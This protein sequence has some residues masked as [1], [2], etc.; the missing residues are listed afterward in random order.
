MTI[1]LRS[2]TRSSRTHDPTTDVE[3]SN[4]PRHLGQVHVAAPMWSRQLTLAGES[5]YVGTRFSSFGNHVPGGWLTNL[6]LTWVRPHH[7]LSLSARV[8]NVFD[9]EY[10]HPVGFEFRQDVIPQDGR[11]ISVRATLRF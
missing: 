6:N 7:P 11:T 9:R 5:Q 4:S 1:T 3:L 10:A 8:A 2:I